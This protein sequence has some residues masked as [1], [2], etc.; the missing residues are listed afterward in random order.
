MV[1]GT[2]LITRSGCNRKLRRVP[3]SSSKAPAG[4]GNALR[5]AAS[6]D[7]PRASIRNALTNAGISSVST[8]SS[9]NE[10]AVPLAFLSLSSLHALS[11]S[12]SHLSR[13]SPYTP[14]NRISR[15]IR[16]GTARNALRI[17]RRR[18]LRLQRWPNA[19]RGYAQTLRIS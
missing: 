13:V 10:D 18:S 1:G 5:H 7:V 17:C 3:V 4:Y 6:G 11:L 14:Q 19:A 12:L 8:P 9:R 16:L 2:G 15:G